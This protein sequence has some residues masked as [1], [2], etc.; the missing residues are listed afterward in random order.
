[1]AVAPP[2]VPSVMI[3]STKYFWLP[4]CTPEEAAVPTACWM[5]FVNSVGPDSVTVRSVLEYACMTPAMPWH[6]PLEP[7]S[8][9]G[10]Q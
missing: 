5:I 10:K 6:G 3:S 2:H 1:M 7:S 9:M 4:W 8:D